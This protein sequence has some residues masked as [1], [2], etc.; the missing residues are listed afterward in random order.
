MK[1]KATIIPNQPI[2]DLRLS[3]EAF[4]VL[5]YLMS[6]ENNTEIDDN[7]IAN[8][9]GFVSY[10]FREYKRELIYLGYIICTDKETIIN[11]EPIQK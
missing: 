3:D 4:R 8:D 6:I 1:F 11:P 9:L 10:R 7:E 5:C 2:T